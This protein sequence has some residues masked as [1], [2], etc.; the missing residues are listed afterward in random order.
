[1]LPALRFTVAS[2]AMVPPPVPSLRVEIPA[3][4]SV[5]VDRAPPISSLTVALDPIDPACLSLM[6]AVS[7]LALKSSPV[8]TLMVALPLICP[9][10]PPVPLSLFKIWNVA[11]P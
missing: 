11:S 5:A 2:E 6:N 9:G 8:L 7:E 1:M 4:R 10:M 3:K